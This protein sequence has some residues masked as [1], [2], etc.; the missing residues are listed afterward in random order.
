MS[1]VSGSDC[2]DSKD[3]SDIDLGI[4]ANE[5]PD[6]LKLPNPLN[7]DVSENALNPPNDPVPENADADA[8]ADADEDAD[9]D[10]DGDADPESEEG[11]KNENLGFLAGGS[12][13]SS[14]SLFIYY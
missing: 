13:S 3:E 7:D 5:I 10:G 2:F 9:A 1:S 12:S 8:D 11:L 4:D 6:G 14:S